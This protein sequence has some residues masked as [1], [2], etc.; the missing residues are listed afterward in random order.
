MKLDLDKLD[1]QIKFLHT[2]AERLDLL[3]A[4]P[5]NQW[6]VRN[7]DMLRGIAETLSALRREQQ[8]TGLGG[9]RIE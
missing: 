9:K 1:R 8:M 6:A 7:A 4:H 5:G 3:Q 2:Q